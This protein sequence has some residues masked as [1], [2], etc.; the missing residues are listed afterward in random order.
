MPKPT[1]ARAGLARTLSHSSH[2]S[3]EART[4]FLLSPIHFSPFSIVTTL[5]T[6]LPQPPLPGG[7]LGMSKE[8]GSLGTPPLLEG[9]G[10]P[11][12][13]AAFHAGNVRGQLV[14]DRQP[15]PRA[16]EFPASHLPPPLSGRTRRL[17]ETEAF[18]AGNVSFLKCRV[19]YFMQPN[20]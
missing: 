16:T 4:N 11:V 15:P 5:G 13:T 3:L 20:S 9:L 14:C 8:G 17:I 10:L 7:E 18:A 2:T 6:L 19:P 12:I 1:L